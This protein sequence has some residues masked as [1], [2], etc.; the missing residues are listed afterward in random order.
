M[1]VEWCGGKN[2]RWNGRFDEGFKV[3]EADGLEHKFAVFVAWADCSWC[4]GWSSNMNGEARRDELQIR[5]KSSVSD[6]LM[7]D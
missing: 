2:I 6:K 4:I 5:E 3:V 1:E 7:G